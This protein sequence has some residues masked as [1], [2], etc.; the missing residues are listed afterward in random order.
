MQVNV[1]DLVEELFEPDIDSS[2]AREFLSDVAND[3]GSTYTA[4]AVFGNSNPRPPKRAGYDRRLRGSRT[5]AWYL[6]PSEVMEDDPLIGTQIIRKFG[7]H[8]VVAYNPDILT[9]V[10]SPDFIRAVD[11]HEKAHGGQ[12]GKGK[13]KRLHAQTRRGGVPVGLMLVEGG[14]EFA[15]ERSG[16]RPPSRYLDER[17][18]ST[19]GLYRDFAYDLEKREPGI[20]RQVYRAASRASLRSV[21][22]LL[23]RVPGIEEI[24]DRYASMLNRQT[25][26]VAA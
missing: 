8:P 20:L 17:G 22:R 23:N 2:A 6:D 3:H 1:P 18:S 5:L 25:L 19:Y 16:R 4:A 12:T 14:A 11:A 10:Y 24:V 15:L 7:P 26:A 13:L 21:A 9:G